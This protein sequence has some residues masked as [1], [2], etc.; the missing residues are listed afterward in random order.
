MVL[1]NKYKINR[2]DSTIEPKEKSIHQE[3]I[4]EGNLNE[5][6]LEDLA[7]QGWK[8]LYPILPEHKTMPESTWVY[9]K[10][11]SLAIIYENIGKD[12]HKISLTTNLERIDEIKNFFE[13][14]LECKLYVEA[15]VELI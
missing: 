9:Q 10:D 3:F 15:P 12:A 7:N 8:K 1:N 4:I 13:N 5:N 11:K 2:M 14:S 6:G